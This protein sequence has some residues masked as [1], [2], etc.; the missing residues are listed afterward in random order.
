MLL[1]LILATSSLSAVDEVHP[2]EVPGTVV[3]VRRADSELEVIRIPEDFVHWESLT[4]FSTTKLGDSKSIYEITG[5]VVSNNSGIP[6]ERI[7][8]Y[9]GSDLHPPR[10]VDLTHEDGRFSFQVSIQEESQSQGVQA[11]SLDKGEIY[12]VDRGL[13]EEGLPKAMARTYSVG[14]I[15]A[16]QKARGKPKR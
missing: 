6:E 13:R 16:Y 4:K 14:D 8:I 7:P 15:L 11:G 5:Q 3:E 2:N 10:L 9:F 12:L 1:P